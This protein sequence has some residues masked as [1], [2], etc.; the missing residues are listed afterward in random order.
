LRISNGANVVLAPG[1]YVIKDGPLIVQN[2]ASMRGID[3]GF[4]LKGPGSKLTF[5]RDST[6][7]LS[8]PRTG[9]MA[10]LLIYDDPSGVAAP[11]NTAPPAPGGN[12]ATRVHKITS[13]NARTLIGTIYMPQ[14][15]LVIDARRPIADRSA[16][17]VI[18]VK[19]IDLHNGPNLVLNA[20]Y[21]AT[22]VPVP[23]GVGPYGSKVTLTD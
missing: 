15:R 20:D 22:D 18:V 3:V 4:F 2:N 14:G 5:A 1:I 19:Q 8:A 16:Y 11:D 12:S 17:T 7:N 10:G 23:E 13:D 6:I 21:N 9:I